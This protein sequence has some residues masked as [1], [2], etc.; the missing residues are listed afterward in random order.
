MHTPHSARVEVLP[1]GSYRVEA[2]QTGF[3]T[4]VQTGIVVGVSRRAQVDPVLSVGTTETV[5]VS[6]DAPL[7]DTTHATLGR[8]VDEDEVLNLPLVDR[9]V[10]T[11][12]ELVPGVDSTETTNVFGSPGQETLV[13][14]SA[15]ASAGAVNYNL[16]GGSNASGLRNTGNPIPNPD[17]IEEFRVSTNSY[18]A[19]YGRF[20]GGVVDVV[21][22][23]GTNDLH[24]SLFEFF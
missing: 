13:N 23:S 14:G 3:Q 6:A 4:F 12:L 22:K 16:D 10:Y 20:A 8:T 11:L 21:T 5:T 1:V 7:V 2:A 24:G 18:S 17:A 19:E 9:D 15:N